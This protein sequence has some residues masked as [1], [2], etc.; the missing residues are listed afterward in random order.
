MVFT[1]D[2]IMHS[3]NCSDKTA[4]KMLV[5][6]ERYGLIERKRQGQG[7]PVLIYV[8][9]FIHSENL[10]FLTR[11]ISDSGPGKSTTLESE[12]VRCNNN[13]VRAAKSA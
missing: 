9:N 2:N 3:L 1:L 5:E 7:K 6:L 8:K 11:K 10:R 4:T 13:K 12:K